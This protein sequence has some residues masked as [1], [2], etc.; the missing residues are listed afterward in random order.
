MKTTEN[1]ELTTVGQMLGELKKYEKKHWDL[2]VVA[3]AEDDYTLGV[4]GMGKDKDGDLQIEVEE[5]EADLEGIWT[6]DDVIDSLEQ[7][8]KDIRVYLAGHGVYF[9]IDSDRCIF[10]DSDDDD[11]VGCYATVFGEYEEEPP[12]VLTEKEKRQ[13]ARRAAWKERLSSWKGIAE[14]LTYLLCIPLMA[15]GLYYNIAALV[16][17]S[18]PAWESI[19]W[20]PFL[21]LLLGVCLYNLFFPNPNEYI[22]SEL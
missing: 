6:V 14:G 11:V 5:V 3:W 18:Q 19:L 20:I 22:I 4:V 15:Y 8:G 17:H 16:K 13:R 12:C 9:A 21:L 7:A 1:I 10:T 2:S